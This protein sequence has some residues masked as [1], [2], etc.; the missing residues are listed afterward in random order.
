[1]FQ[2][3]NVLYCE[4]TDVP[5]GSGDSHQVEVTEVCDV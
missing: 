2:R 3:K 4:G 1:V 5:A